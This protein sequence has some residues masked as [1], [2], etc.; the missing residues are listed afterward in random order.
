MINKSE[1]LIKNLIQKIN[2]WKFIFGV[3]M[4]VSAIVYSLLM[5][6]Q[7]VNRFDGLWHGSISYANGWELSLGRWFLRFLDKARFY[8]SPDP[9]TSLLTMAVFS[10]SIILVLDL[11]EV[12]NKYISILVSLLFLINVSVCVTLSYRFT[13]LNYGFSCFLAVFA[14]WLIIKIKKMWSTI[15]AALAIAVMLGCYQANIGCTC[16]LLLVYIPF[17]LYKLNMTSKDLFR[18]IGKTAMTFVLGGISYFLL[19]YANLKYYNI[20]MSSYNGASK[21]NALDTILNLPK[22]ILDA[23][24]DFIY[25]YSNEEI[26]ANILSEQLYVIIFILLLI[27]IGYGIKNV[28]RTNKL[29]ALIYLF[30]FILIPVACNASILIAYDSITSIQ[31]TMPMALCI[32]VLLCF[33]SNIELKRCITVYAIK[34]ITIGSLVLI[35]YGNYI[36]VQYDQQA[37]YMGLVSTKTLTTQISERLLQLDL[38]RPEYQYCFIGKPSDNVLFNKNEVIVKAN[39]YARFGDFGVLPDCVRQSWYGFW[40]NEMGINIKIVD[41]DWYVQAIANEAIRQMPNFPAN[42][43]CAMIDDVVV[44]KISDSY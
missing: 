27:L 29:H 8:L 19:L 39:D 17:R 2:Q 38:F 43:A 10:V 30:C 14:A 6:N 36:M 20:K 26:R 23:Y 4:I 21:Y 15:F 40:T 42:G 32:P 35:L 28:F 9:I 34:L 33:V 16:F 24:K 7:L 44:I 31:M 12:Q 3:N 5:C 18:Y 1:E 37:M 22:S 25:Y 41:D 13:S 11:F